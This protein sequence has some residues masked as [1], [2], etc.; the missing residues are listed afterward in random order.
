MT[1]S[2]RSSLG[3]IADI[4][5]YVALVLIAVIAGFL[6]FD[7]PAPP[8]LPE[9]ASAAPRVVIPPEGLLDRLSRQARSGDVVSQ[10]QLGEMYYRG[11]EVRQDYDEAIKWLRMAGDKGDKIAARYMGFAYSGGRGVAVDISEAASWWRLA[12][13]KGDDDSTYQLAFAYLNGKGVTKSESEGLSYCRL[14][15]ER[16]HH[17]SGW[18]PMRCYLMGSNH[19]WGYIT[20]DIAPRRDGH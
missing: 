19:S 12:S 11:L 10:R 3:S 14:A 13:S 15:A 9:P 6:Y 2:P 7:K 8:K 1:T 20:P 5:G 4:I 17:L 18:S 16:G